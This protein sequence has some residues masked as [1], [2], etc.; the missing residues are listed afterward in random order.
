MMSGLLVYGTFYAHS[1]E[2]KYIHAIAP[3]IISQSS[4]GSALQQVAFEQPD[5]LMVYGSSEMFVENTPFLPSRF[6]QNYPT[7]FE[8][9]AVARVNSTSL[10]IAQ[11]LA[12]I[13]PELHGKRVVF[14]FT[15]SMFNEKE[16]SPAAYAGNFS[17]LHA[18]ALIF[19]QSLS[20]GTK[21]LAAQRMNEYPDTLK[22]D[23]I[24]QFAVQQLICPCSYGP[25]LY[26]LAMPLGEINTWIIRLQDHWEV[27]NYIWNDLKLNHVVSRRRTRINWASDIKQGFQ[28][29][30]IV[31]DNNHY[32][33][34]KYLW[35]DQY[36]K[37][38]NQPKKPGSEDFRFLWN[39]N[40]S[41]E[42]TDFELALQVLTEFGAKPLIL[43]R[44][45]D[46]RVWSAMGISRLARTAYYAKL[47][48][49]IAP[50]SFPIV[51]FENYDTDKYFS[52]D[53]SS[54]PGPEGSVYVDQTLDDFFHGNLH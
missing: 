12:A 36:S 37:T 50:Y 31:S 32:G 15:P 1:M 41:K 24:L 25:T 29:E 7:G 23:P 5:L 9:Y 48:K 34:E 33:I 38:L 27:V 42:W 6:F 54:H 2:Q 14:S 53:P 39:L 52:I 17:L 45:I 40:H 30:K 16:V 3:L 18:D 21:Q 46:G 8:V 22:A 47:Q 20:Y 19:N 11:D 10:N 4:I 35:T 44:P 13:G 26:V 51:D 43:S 28:A 49:T